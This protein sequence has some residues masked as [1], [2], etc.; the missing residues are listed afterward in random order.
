LP[1]QVGAAEHLTA[2]PARASEDGPVF[3]EHVPNALATA[4]AAIVAP[5]AS[6]TAA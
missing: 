3:G 2:L 5:L 6:F 4:I 1:E